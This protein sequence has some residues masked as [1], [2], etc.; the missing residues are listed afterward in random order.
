M[1]RIQHTKSNNTLLGQLTLRQRITVISTS[2]VLGLGLTMLLFLNNLSPIFINHSVGPMD[3]FVLVD[4]TNALGTPTQVWMRT[5]APGSLRI[6]LD[7]GVIDSDPTVWIKAISILALALI[8]FL[9]VLGAQWIANTAI[10]P[11]K[12]IND[13][14]QQIQA[15]SLNQRLDYQGPND[16]IKTLADSF[17]EMLLRLETNF[18]DQEAFTGNLA[19]QLRTPLSTLKANLEFLATDPEAGIEEYKEFTTNATNSLINLEHLVNDLL[20]L[21][22]GESEMRFEPL[23]IQV[24]I[25]EVISDLTSLANKKEVQVS[26]HGKS[27]L[28]VRGDD[29][30]LQQAFK[31]L[32][33]NGILYSDKGTIL[34][35]MLEGIPGWCIVRVKD[36]GVGISQEDQAHIFE[37]FYRGKMTRERRDGTGL[38]LAITAHIVKLHGG[39]L[40]VQSEEGEGSVFSVYLPQ[41]GLDEDKSSGYG[42]FRTHAP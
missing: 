21:S 8:V 9:G 15:R 13:T 26:F 11:I 35:L 38:G 22:R 34:H 18:K 24:L 4:S 23:F 17:D 27:D 6:K 42:H 3:N 12:Q 33:Q 16:E 30:L 29:I 40:E 41:G 28:M 10:Q 37:R 20:L 31:N 36:C 2:V 19:H 39:K 7:A 32:I 1:K 25:E 5:P 14:T